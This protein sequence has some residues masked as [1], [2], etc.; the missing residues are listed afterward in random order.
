MHFTFDPKQINLEVMARKKVSKKQKKVQARLLI[1]L[2]MGIVLGLGFFVPKMSGLFPSCANSISCI[3]DLSGA[4]EPGQEGVFLGKKVVPPS[5]MADKQ[6]QKPVL[7]VTTEEKHI[8]VDLATQT[9][10]A[11]EGGKLMFTFPVS[12]G[13]WGRTPTGDFRIWVKLRNTRMSGGNTALGTYYNLPNV[14]YTMYFS[15]ESA[16]RDMG[17]SLHGAYWHNNFG[18][19]MS[20]GCVNMRPIDAQK[21]YD[22]ADPP[23]ET[24]TTTTYV[25]DKNPGT[26]ITIFGQ[27]PNE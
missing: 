8:F 22:W 11:Y 23:T 25:T 26:L 19:P 10:T 16:S 5:Y 2:G 27:P 6:S 24:G 3:K 12:T 4:Y 1:I 7:G 18:Y 17:Y 14:P 13:K 15:G 20:H 21:I 9:L